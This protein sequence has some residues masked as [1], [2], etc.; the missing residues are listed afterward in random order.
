MATWH[1]ALFRPAL[2]FCFAMK[3]TIFLQFIPPANPLYFSYPG[4]HY[5]DVKLEGHASIVDSDIQLTLNMMDQTMKKSVGQVTSSKPMHLWDQKSGT[6]AN[7]KSNFSFVIF[8]DEPLH[9]DGLTIFMADPNIPFPVPEHLEEGG[10]LGLV[11]GNQMFNSTNHPFVAVEFDTYENSWDPNTTHIGMNINSVI[12]KKTMPW[13]ADISN[14]NVYNC[15]INYNATTY[16][17]SV[18]FT[19]YRN[20][21]PVEQYFSYRVDLRK[22]LPEWVV[23]GIS[24]ANGDVFEKKTMGKEEEESDFD[25]NMDEEFQKDTGP[26]KFCYYELETATNNFSQEEKL[27]QGG[28]GGVYRGYLKNSN[29]YVAIKRISQES[30]QGIKEYATE[31][32]IISKL[33]HRNLVQ[34]IGWC[35]KKKDLLLIYEFM[36]NG[37]LDFH[38]YHGKSVLTWEED[39]IT[40][41]EWVW[42]MYGIG[43]LHEAID[44]KLCGVFDEQQVERLVV[45]GLCCAHPDYSLRPS[46][47]QVIQVL[48]FEV[49]LPI[50]P[51]K[52]PV[53]TYLP[54]MIKDA[55]YQ[56]GHSFEAACTQK[57]ERGFDTHP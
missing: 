40:I 44:P 27:G 45:A 25:V 3:I 23:L 34:L 52:M 6:L 37:S 50:L 14:R 38:L 5:G 51:Q 53:P 19:G 32:K 17:F 18:T 29:S 30:K 46:V 33:R 39:Q 55:F 54:P 16:N 7:F 48:N 8:S 10:G 35:H 57:V 28:F 26:K 56:I 41:T 4:F 1:I 2:V 49:P 36:P 13:L 11:D 20:H 21:N 15:S 42:E 47:R 24:A 9:G 31:V 12:S 43:K 22:I